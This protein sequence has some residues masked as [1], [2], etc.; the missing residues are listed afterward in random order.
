MISDNGK[1]P[2]AAAKVLQ[3]VKW[4]FNVPKAPGGE[5][6]LNA[7]SIQSNAGSGR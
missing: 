3:D 7:W 6:Y 5:D 4:V 2:E 1:M